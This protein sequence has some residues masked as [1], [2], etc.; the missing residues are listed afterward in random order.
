MKPASPLKISIDF[1][2][3]NRIFPFFILLNENMEILMLGKSLNSLV[4]NSSSQPFLSLFRFKNSPE[5][6]VEFSA[7]KES[8]EEVFVLESVSKELNLELKGQFEF[9]VESNQLIFCVRRGRK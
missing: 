1:R 4:S 2:Q 5:Q 8:F 9:L 6:S 7:L 3:W